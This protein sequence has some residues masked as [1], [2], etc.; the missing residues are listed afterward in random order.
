VSSQRLRRRAVRRSARPERRSR[1]RRGRAADPAGS[2]S[3]WLTVANGR[4]VP[5][6]TATLM[7]LAWLLSAPED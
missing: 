2:E 3:Y 5:V 1:D 7:T 6:D 4:P